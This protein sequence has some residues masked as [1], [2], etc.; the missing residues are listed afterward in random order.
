MVSQLA[1]LKKYGIRPKKW[2]GQNFLVDNDILEEIVTLY[3]LGEDE[4]VVE[5]GAGLGSLTT[6]LAPKVRKVLAVEIDKTLAG[7][8]RDRVIN[9]NNVEV[10]NQN[11]LNFD[12]PGIAKLHG[13]RLKVLGNIPYNISTPLIFKL[14]E[15]RTCV[16]MA[17]LMFQKEVAQ[18]IV[19][20][21]DTKEY[22]ILSVFS[23]L[24]AIV[25]KELI[26]PRHHFYPQ[27]KV[28]STLVRFLFLKTPLIDIKD[29]QIFKRVVK[30][31]FAQR[32]K[33]L[34][35]ALKNSLNIDIHLDDVIKAMKAC[36]IDPQRRGETLSLEEFGDLSNHLVRYQTYDR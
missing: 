34:K 36:G 29:E 4:Q 27:P 15:S 25:S 33:T 26:V 35:N 3:D 10:I 22:G 13:H 24:N 16:S 12:F 28:D 32:R 6:R 18:R 14:I 8:L 21:P 20:V 5:I 9:D 31:S 11:I 19:A 1:Q 17:V 2:L 23:Q 7:L 30:A